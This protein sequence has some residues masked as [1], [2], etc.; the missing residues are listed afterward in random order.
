MCHND[1]HTA[2]YQDGVDALPEGIANGQIRL[3]FYSLGQVPYGKYIDR[4]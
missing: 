4:Y 3:R 1:N 2:V